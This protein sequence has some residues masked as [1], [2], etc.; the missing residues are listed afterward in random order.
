[1][2]LINFGFISF[3]VSDLV[4]IIIFTAVFYKLFTMVKD[5]RAITMFV[6]VLSIILIGRV[7]DFFNLTII[8]WIIDSLSTIFWLAFFIIFQPELRRILLQ[9]GQNRFVRKIFKIEAKTVVKEVAEAAFALSEKRFG[10]LFVL[11]KNMGL[12]GIV[13]TGV[14]LKSE[15][16]SDLLISIFFPRSPLHDGAVLISN[17]VLVAARC[18]LPL[19]QRHNLESKYGTRHRAAIGLTEESDA[20]VV[21]VSEETGNISLAFNGE[22]LKVDDMETLVNKINRIFSQG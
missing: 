17:D 7:A 19:S 21:V 13:E 6:G 12:K 16:N 3:G 4:D 1:M 15:V 22:I 14:E 9:L 2:T 5:T 18:I 10:G 11:Q 20:V 8:S